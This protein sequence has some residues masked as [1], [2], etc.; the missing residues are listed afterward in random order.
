MLSDNKRL[1]D[2]AT[3]KQI[4]VEGVK[5]QQTRDFNFVLSELKEEFDKLLGRIK[6]KTLDGLTKAELNRLLLALR[7]SQARIY[8]NYTEQVMQQLRDF[9]NADAYVTKIV[10]ASAKVEEDDE[11]TP[12]LTEAEA[13]SVMVET[14]DEEHNVIPMFGVATAMDNDKLWSKVLN[15][16][17]PANGIYLIPF[18]KGFA[19][20]AQASIENLIRKGYANG[21][22]VEEVIAEI[23]GEGTAQGAST[24]LQKIAVQ[25][26]AVLATA[27]QHTTSIVGG[28]IQS[29][30]FAMY[31]W[32]SVMD[33]KTTDIC[34][35][36]NLK[37]YR[38]GN[39]PLPPA[40]IRCRSHIAPIVG[41]EPGFA[42]E[43]FYTWYARQPE[44]V[45]DDV[46]TEETASAVRRGDLKAKDLPR[47][48]ASRPLTLAQFRKLIREILTR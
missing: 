13:E 39:G 43:S 9:M 44:E 42:A 5:L 14:T 15:A 48:E 47:F 25:A 40:H 1:Y 17:I 7:K 11:E 20:S 35:S 6:Y 27:T 41:T 4:Y 29:A 23:T 37:V 45:Q 21:S 32:Y 34:V 24:A 31:G 26:A 19:V 38:Y 2:I 36:R 16:P 10:F 3:R 28:A 33:G 22:S 8:S 30:I 12:T 18:I 46:L